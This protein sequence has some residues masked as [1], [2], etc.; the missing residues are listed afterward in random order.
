MSSSIG[1]PRTDLKVSTS[2][3]HIPR[4]DGGGLFI[5]SPKS[6]HKSTQ[7]PCQ[8]PKPPNPKIASVKSTSKKTPV[9]SDSSTS[10]IKPIKGEKKNGEISSSEDS[11]SNTNSESNSDSKSKSDS[12]S[13]RICYSETDL[14]ASKL[15]ETDKSLTEQN[16]MKQKLSSF[17]VGSE[18]DENSKGKSVMSDGED[19]L[20]LPYENGKF[21]NLFTNP[22]RIGEGS[23]GIVYKVVHKLDKKN[24]AVKKIK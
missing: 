5:T 15:E 14:E 12:A 13:S 23:Y 6:Q 24:Y 10:K 17:L 22:V 20:T 16:K 3:P 7:S 19:Q 4:T 9:A 11:N 8:K 18:A 2:K 21:K 1:K